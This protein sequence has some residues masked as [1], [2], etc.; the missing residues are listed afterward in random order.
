MLE[1]FIGNYIDLQ[2]GNIIVVAC[3]DEFLSN[4][5]PP[6][7]TWLEDMGSSEVHQ[8]EYGRGFALIGIY[9]RDDMC[10]EK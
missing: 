6:S 8:L 7:K 5:S 3:K 9:G 2:K 4:L 10:N 1:S